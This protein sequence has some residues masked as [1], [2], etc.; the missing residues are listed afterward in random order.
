MRE[1][2]YV[3]RKEAAPHKEKIISLIKAVQKEAKPYFTF[4]F[5]FI[6][7]SSRNMITCEV[8]GNIGYDFD[9]NIEPN[10][11]EG[12]YSPE[13]IRNVIFKA[14]Q[15]HMRQFGYSKIENS[16]SVITLKAVDKSKS[17]IEH[18]CDVAI[19]RHCNDG[20]QKYIRYN[21]GNNSYFS[22]EFRDKSY[23]IGDKLH[24]I[25]KNNYK[26]LLRERYLTYKGKNNNP[27]KHS[28]T[29]FAETVSNTYH[30][31]CNNHN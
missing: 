19:V 29:L 26:S 16:K 22:W 17:K 30:E 31:K 10:V 11:P 14:F 7:S 3:S 13:F 1:F 15:K 6:G 27:D 2:K 25:E 4:R 20:R 28:R 5:D 9:L 8:K 23:Y 21:K 12:K 18:S 24:W